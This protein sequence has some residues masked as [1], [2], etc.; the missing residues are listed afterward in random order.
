MGQGIALDQAGNVYVTGMWGGCGD[1]DCDPLIGNRLFPTT[2]AVWDRTYNGGQGDA[3]VS[4]LNNALSRLV[5]SSYIGGTGEDK[6]WGIAASNGIAYVVGTV[7][8]DGFT[9]TGS[10]E[11]QSPEATKFP[12]KNPIEKSS[13]SDENQSEDAFLAIFDTTKQGGDSLRS[14]SLIGGAQGSDTDEDTARA[15]ALLGTDAYIAG[16]TLNATF[17]T[18][19]GAF[20]TSFNGIADAFVAKIDTAAPSVVMK[21]EAAKQQLA[22]RTTPAARDMKISSAPR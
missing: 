22:T 4:K 16:G 15:I 20:D 11:P 18:T 7:D 1:S 10:P 19:P 14:S 12:Q 8:P 2:D 13:P 9:D 21:V 6:G 17:P 3:F 5:Y